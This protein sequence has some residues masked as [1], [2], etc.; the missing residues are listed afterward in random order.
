MKINEPITLEEW[1][2]LSE[3]RACPTTTLAAT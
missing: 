3:L 2:L 1:T